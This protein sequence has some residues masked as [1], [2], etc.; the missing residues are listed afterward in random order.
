MRNLLVLAPDYPDKDNKMFGSIFVKEQ[1]QYV[2]EFFD[3]VYVIAPVLNTFGLTPQSKY[4]KPYSYDNVQVFF[5][6][7]LFYPRSI[8]IFPIS[9]YIKLNYDNRYKVTLDVV[10]KHNLIFHIIHSHMTFPSTYT[11][12]KLKERYGT[13]VISTIHE[14]SVWL[15]EEMAM[16]HPHLDYSWKNADMLVRVNEKEIPLLQ[17]YNTNVRFVPNG[18]TDIYK[19]I[20]KMVCRSAL[21][22]SLTDKI[23]FSYGSFDERKGFQDLIRA[24]Y[25]CKYI[26]NLKCYISGDGPYKS[27]LQ[28]MIVK[29]KLENKIILLGFMPDNMILYWLNA[30]DIFVFPS[31]HESFGI[32]QL[33][34]LA[35]GTPVVASTN[36]GSCEIIC[37]KCGLLY[38]VGDARDLSEKLYEYFITDYQ[39]FSQKSIR[40]YVEDKYSWTNISKQLIGLYKELL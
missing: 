20:D 34:A 21:G 1:V 35:C 15:C 29:N 2:K 22:L 3:H 28:D 10:Q 14:D 13:P 33:N 27:V 37:D 11:A 19:P 7:C 17:N 36:V 5:P 9:N 25:I 39:L 24:I 30:A 6:S 31:L 23:V 12:C 16:N 18:Y 38:K 26:K 8:T 4:C 40:E 32:T